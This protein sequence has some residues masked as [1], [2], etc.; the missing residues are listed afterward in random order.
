MNHETQK[1]ESTK[2]TLNL[3]AVFL[4]FDCRIQMYYSL[5]L[6]SSIF[7]NTCLQDHKREEI[8]SM[9]SN[10]KSI[11]VLV[12]FRGV[13]IWNWEVVLA[14]FIHSSTCIFTQSF[15]DITIPFFD[16]NIFYCLVPGFRKILR[17]GP[18]SRRI[19]RKKSSVS[20]HLMTPANPSWAHLLLLFCWFF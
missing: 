16:C 10:E 5:L 6:Q 13:L 8:V 20:G 11:P 17:N 9:E 12:Q 1:F 4:E 15:A 18:H 14:A 2:K 3:R 19:L 7:P